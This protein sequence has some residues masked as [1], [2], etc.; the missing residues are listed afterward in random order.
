MKQKLQQSNKIEMKKKIN[1]IEPKPSKVSAVMKKKAPL[2]PELI[3]NLKNLQDKYDVLENENNQNIEKIKM[4]ESK[5]E[6]VEKRACGDLKHPISTSVSVQTDTIL[7]CRQCDFQV[8]D[9]Y[10]FYGH[11]WTEHEDDELGAKDIEKMEVSHN[12]S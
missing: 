11:R 2:K 3:E 6:S 8:D 7:S 9:I 1:L 4:L 12:E 5:L 10:E